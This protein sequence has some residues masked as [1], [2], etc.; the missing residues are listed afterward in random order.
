MS[1]HELVIE[2]DRG[3]LDN[4]VVCNEQA[5]APCRLTCDHGCE[6]WYG[7]LLDQQ[8]DKWHPVF[9]DAN[10]AFV[11][12]SDSWHRMNDYGDCNVELFINESGMVTELATDGHP[13]FIAARVPI[14]EEW[15][16]DGYLW[17]VK[18]RAEEA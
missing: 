9:E 14:V 17:R 12:N 10:P 13:S 7:P 5:G 6:E 8:G 3:Y 1:A 18:E 16:G 15:D 2:W 11:G 4:K